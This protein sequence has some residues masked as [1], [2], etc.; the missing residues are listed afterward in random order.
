[1]NHKPLIIAHR[2]ASGLVPE[3][4]LAAFSKAIDIGVDRI[5]MDLRQTIDGEVV[6]LHDKTINRT[7]NG[8][9]SVRKLSLKRCQRCRFLVSS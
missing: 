8:W 6:V 7:T 4:T 1:M 9:G 3:N 5:E 2:G